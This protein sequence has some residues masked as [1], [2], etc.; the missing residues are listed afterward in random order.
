M[1]NLHSATRQAATTP[2]KHSSAPRLRRER[3][4]EQYSRRVDNFVLSM[5]A[6]PFVIQEH[7]DPPS[8]WTNVGERQPTTAPPFRF[9]VKKDLITRTESLREPLPV[10]Q[11]KFRE[12][13]PEKEIQPAMRFVSKTSLDRV[14][15]KVRE[16]HLRDIDGSGE[17][18]S[19]A[20]DSEGYK[21]IM[22]DMSNTERKIFI[23]REIAKGMLPFLHHK[24]HFKAVHSKLTPQP[25]PNQSPPNQPQQ[26]V[27]LPQERLDQDLD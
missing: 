23:A 18:L 5:V 3:L 17:P 11:H 19:K 14:Q 6:Q 25:Q 24:T 26:D 20:M 8:Q 22:K 2:P 4:V 10:L 7:K 12:R 15:E 13:S 9:A 27:F 21:A 16:T 1:Y